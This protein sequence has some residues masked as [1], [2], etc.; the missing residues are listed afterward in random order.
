MPDRSQ[1]GESARSPFAGCT[2]MIA[3]LV[4]MTFLLGFSVWSL[5]RLD[6]EIAA[7]T[8]PEAKPPPVAPL[9]GIE[10]E[11]NDLMARLE[12]FRAQLGN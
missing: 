11:L 4:V 9:D 3:A 8:S 10:A 7:F 6:S 12:V 2:V 1:P 5:F